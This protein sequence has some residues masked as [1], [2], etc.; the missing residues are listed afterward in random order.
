M[1]VWNLASCVSSFLITS[2][3][4]YQTMSLVCEWTFIT[5]HHSSIRLLIHHQGLPSFSELY[6][7]GFDY[8]GSIDSLLMVPLSP[9]LSNGSITDQEDSS[10]NLQ[11]P[12]F[13]VTPQAEAIKLI[14]AKW[15]DSEVAMALAFSTVCV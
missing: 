7:Q 1:V 12:L 13:P 14:D 5:Q 10:N 9:A 11:D 2:H 8:A 15:G 3:V 4:P 6:A